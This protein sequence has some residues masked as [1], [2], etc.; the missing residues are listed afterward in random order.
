MENQY[1]STITK[2]VNNHEWQTKLTSK[3]NES[4]MVKINK[5]DGY[6]FINNAEYEW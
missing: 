6:E 2:I 3:P 5:Y 4:Q 1:E